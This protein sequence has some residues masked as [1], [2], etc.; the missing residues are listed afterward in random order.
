M[1][2]N[3]TFVDLVRLFTSRRKFI[4]RNVLITMLVAVGVS[5]LLSNYY[6]ATTIF[7]PASPD[8]MKPEHIFGQSNQPMEYYGTGLDLDRMLTVAQSNE[9]VDFMVDSFNLFK[10]YKI[11]TSRKT[12][13]YKVQN[14]FRKLYNVEKTKLDAIELSVEDTDPVISASMANA[15][16]EKINELSTNLLKEN[17]IELSNTLSNT[18]IK[19]QKEIKNLNDSIDFLRN[20][21]HIID[22]EAQSEL[23]VEKLLSTETKL[24]RD[25][26]RLKILSSLPGVRKDTVTM[27]RAMVAGLEMEYKSLVDTGG[28]SI[29]NVARLNEGRNQLEILLAQ[30]RQ[31][32]DYIASYTSRLNQLLSVLQGKDNSLHLVAKADVPLVKSRPK[33]SMIVLLCGLAALFFSLFWILAERSLQDPEWRKLWHD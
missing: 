9:L 28:N 7:Y 2:P 16:R 21:Y 8:V 5:L 26:E 31:S 25:K 19:K 13:R 15:A 23:I 33:R 20:K 1:D 12:A 6:Q 3:Q 29:M 18:L 30:Q 32:K 4:I 14:A 27:L 24:Q 17:I 11:D 22:P 10:R